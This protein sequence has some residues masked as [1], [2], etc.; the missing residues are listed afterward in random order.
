MPAGPT[1]PP[2]PPSALA[3]SLPRCF[4]HF[5][6]F[7]QCRRGRTQCFADWVWIGEKWVTHLVWTGP[8]NPLKWRQTHTQEQRVLLSH[9]PLS[10][11]GARGGGTL[12]ISQPF[13]LIM[14]T[15]TPSSHIFRA[16]QT[17]NVPETTISCIH[18]NFYLKESSW[19]SPVCYKVTYQTPWLTSFLIESLLI[20]APRCDTHISV[21]QWN[22]AERLAKFHEFL[23]MLEAYK[24]PIYHNL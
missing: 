20:Y 5:I 6:V 23:S 12:L 4:P 24:I 13:Y 3:L 22:Q 18:G 8:S 1:L 9:F 14:F 2:L 11:G 15:I 16:N 17:I 7:L 21:N 19:S 10:G